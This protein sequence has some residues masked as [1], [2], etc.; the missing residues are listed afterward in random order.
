MRYK[1]SSAVVL[2]S[3]ALFGCTHTSVSTVP[4]E[5][6][7]HGLVYRYEGRANFSHQFAEADKAMRKTCLEINGGHPV[8]VS[9]NKR[10]LGYVDLGGTQYNET[11]YATITGIRIAVTT[12]GTATGGASPMLNQNQEI[13]FKCSK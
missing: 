2:G 7:G 5:V 6:S 8:V 3:L 9:V 1:T 4:V 11:S 10:N 13:L 12:T